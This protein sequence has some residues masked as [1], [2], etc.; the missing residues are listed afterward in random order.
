VSTAFKGTPGGRL[1]IPATF[2]PG[3][4]RMVL[5]PYY[6]SRVCSR[7]IHVSYRATKVFGFQACRP[8]V[9]WGPRSWR[10]HEQTG[11]S[12]QRV[13]RRATNGGFRACLR[14]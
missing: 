5:H 1:L 11:R 7:E 4:C 10:T 6:G 14:P 9:V 8:G 2:R 3:N 13:C 12:R